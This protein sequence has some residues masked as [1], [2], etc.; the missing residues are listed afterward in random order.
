MHNCPCCDDIIY[1]S[2]MTATCDECVQAGCETRMVDGVMAYTDCQ[3]PDRD[4]GDEYAED[5]DYDDDSYDEYAPEPWELGP[6][7]LDMPSYAS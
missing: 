3:L 7:P 5:D 6:D 1:M 4:W 2:D